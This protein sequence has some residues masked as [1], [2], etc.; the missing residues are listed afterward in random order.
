MNIKP[1]W[2]AAP[3]WAKF[4]TQDSTGYWF[5]HAVEPSRIGNGWYGVGLQAMAQSGHGKW[6]ESLEGRP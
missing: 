1:S 2:D 3:D 4:L 5:W 6:K